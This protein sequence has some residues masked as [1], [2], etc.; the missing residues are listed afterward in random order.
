MGLRS[1]ICL[2][3]FFS[4]REWTPVRLRELALWAF[5][6]RYLYIYMVQDRSRSMCAYVDSSVVYRP[7]AVHKS[8]FAAHDEHMCIYVCHRSA[9]CTI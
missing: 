5:V 4:R 3:L 6:R 2:S 8:W 1:S 9:M 7:T